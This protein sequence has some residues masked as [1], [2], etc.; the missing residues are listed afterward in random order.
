MYKIILLSFFITMFN[1]YEVHKEVN[2][3]NELLNRMEARYTVSP[4]SLDNYLQ[5]LDNLKI[6][7]K[8]FVN[9][10]SFIGLIEMIFLIIMT[11]IIVITPLVLVYFW[12]YYSLD[13]L[14]KFKKREDLK[15]FL[16]VNGKMNYKE[17][18]ISIW[19]RFRKTYS[20]MVGFGFSILAWSLVS[21]AYIFKNFDQINLGLKEYFHFPFKVL[22]GLGIINNKPKSSIPLTEVWFEMIFIVIISI[23]VFFAGYYLGRLIINIR[24]Q[25]PKL[26]N[27]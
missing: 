25:R 27:T 5:E 3:E 11:I 18:P 24:Y 14:I 20:K 8:S 6:T 16:T 1:N 17:L 23:L 22:N 12:A 13:Y 9:N 19:T 26:S 7:E 10:D 4:I 21:N 2:F 15:D